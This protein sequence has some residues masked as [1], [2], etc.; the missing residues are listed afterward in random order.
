[1]LSF[2]C[3]VLCVVRCLLFV[4]RCPL[5]VVRCSFSG[6][7]SVVIWCFGVCWLLFVVSWFGVC[8]VLF[9]VWSVVVRLWPL[10]CGVCCFAV[11]VRCVVCCVLLGISCVCVVNCC[12]LFGVW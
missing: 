3:C 8:C 9:V 12:L 7:W 6:V 4:V 2:V 1:M 11:G 5:F 10:V